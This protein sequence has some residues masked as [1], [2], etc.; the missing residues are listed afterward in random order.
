MGIVIHTHSLN[1]NMPATLARVLVC[2]Y[3]VFFRLFANFFFFFCEHINIHCEHWERRVDVSHDSYFSAKWRF[4]SAVLIISTNSQLS[5]QESAWSHFSL[6]CSLTLRRAHVYLQTY[7][8]SWAFLFQ[9]TNNYYTRTK[10]K[11]SC[12]CTAYDVIVKWTKELFFLA[13]LR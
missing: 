9:K 11:H 3:F 6:F 4:S 10:K 8:H 2:L 1:W 12:A 13:S 7:K 5:L